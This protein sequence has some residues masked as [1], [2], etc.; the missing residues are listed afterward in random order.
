M[1]P[2]LLHPDRDYDFARKIPTN[3]ADLE[4]DLSLSV[5]FDA[6]ANGDK[7]MREGA[8]HII[9]VGEST[10]E[11]LVYRQQVLQDSLRNRNVVRSLHSL[12]RESLNQE[13]RVFRSYFVRYP[14][15][16]LRRSIEVMEIFIESLQTLQQIAE[17]EADNFQ[18]AGF[19]RFFA[20]IRSELSSEYIG[21]VKAILQELDFEEGVWVSAALGQGNKGVAYTLRKSNE[22][23]QT[24]FQ[25]LLGSRK[26]DF[27]IEIAERDENGARALGELRDRGINEAANVLAQSVDHILSFFDNMQRELS[28]Y[29]SCINLA[30]Q[31]TRKGRTFCMP[32][33][34]LPT[35]RQHAFSGLCEIGLALQSPLPVVGNSTSI[36]EYNPVI[37]TGANQ[38]GKTTYLRSVGQAQ[39]MMQAGMF[40]AADSFCDP[41]CRGLFTHFRR[42]EDATMKSGKLDEE[43]ARMSELA[44]R[45][46]SHSLILF[47]ESFAATNEREGAEISLQVVKALVGEKVKVFFVTHQFAFSGALAEESNGNVLFLRAD[48]QPDG[49]RSFII[50]QGEPLSTSF[51]SDLFMQIFA[52]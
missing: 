4:Q 33:A 2:F 32:Q 28:F 43:L 19:Q 45:L 47:N 39:L 12:A 3:A 14:A 27:L 49:S 50:A 29:V 7:E 9:L 44:E 46:R 31:L 17:S 1:K 22:L 13:K 23:P 34:G 48:R 41:L 8:R 35:S 21:S 42:E 36:D 11:S 40:V 52:D 37:I 5:L 16:I 15:A 18:S 30:E 10:P 38:G 24:W 6:M 20:M 26:K 25:R 51:G